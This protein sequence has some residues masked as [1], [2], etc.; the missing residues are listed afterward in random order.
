MLFEE[1]EIKARWEE[2]V[3]ELY[4]DDRGDAPEIEDDD[5]EEVMISEIEKAIREMGKASGND[6]ITSEMIKALDDE[7]I[8]NFH[9]LVNKIYNCG[10]I[11]ASMN[12]STFIR[13]PKKQQCAQST[14]H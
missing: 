11:P 14:E 2:Y 13:L 8:K 1:D 12:E 6:M 9:Q 10:K 4:N 7:G 5:G 3:S